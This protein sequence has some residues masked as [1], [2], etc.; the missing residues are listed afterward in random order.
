MPGQD[1]DVIGFSFCH[2]TKAS[3]AHARVGVRRLTRQFI[4]RRDDTARWPAARLASQAAV[5]S[6]G[7]M[8]YSDHLPDDDAS[9]LKCFTPVIDVIILPA[10]PYLILLLC[11]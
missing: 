3:S 7:V 5:R 6:D 1:D 9:F 10:S 8:R 2:N 11:A 4:L